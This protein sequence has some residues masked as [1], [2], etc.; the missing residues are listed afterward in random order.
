MTIKEQ[1]IHKIRQDWASNSRWA[2]IKRPYSAEE[3]LKLRGTMP[4]QDT[5]AERGAEKLWKKLN[6]QDCVGALGAM[7]GNQAI[8]EVAAGLEAIYLSGWQVA[9]DANVAGQMYPD[10]SLYPANSVPLVVKRINNAFQRRDQIQSVSGE[11]NIDWFAPIVADAEA[12]FGGNLNAYELMRDMIE[13]GAAGV[14]FEDQLSSAKKCGHLGGKVLVPTQ[15]AINKL[16][17]ARLAADVCDVPTVLIARTDAEAANLITSDI[18]E[19]DR[20]FLAGNRTNEGFYYYKNGLEA[21]IA[22]G[23]AYAEYADLIW[24]ETSNPDLGLA[25]EFAAEIHRVHP[26]KML[27]Y[28]CSPSFNWS[29]YMSIGDMEQFRDRIAA[30]GYKFQFIT[31]AGFHALNTSMF[32]LSLAYKQRGMAGFSELQQREFALQSKGFTAVKHQTFVGTQYFDFVQ[33]V[34]QQGKSSTTAM[35]DSTESAQFH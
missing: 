5:L 31:L 21:C 4:I 27:A 18:D 15:E 7:T 24:M 6:S 2:G 10:Q 16:V 25:A 3:V 30:L 23:I 12:G 11:G 35:A 34:V 22:R 13:A 19:R 32:E 14:H 9:A 29:K 20:P 17:A 8:Q 1:K 26:G 28:N 33:D